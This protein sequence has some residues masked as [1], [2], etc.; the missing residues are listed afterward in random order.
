MRGC[1]EVSF[2]VDFKKDSHSSPFHH[3]VVISYCK[4]WQRMKI[5][6]GEI[7]F[8]S[9]SIHFYLILVSFVV[10]E[11][12]LNDWMRKNEGTILNQGKT[13]ISKISFIPRS[14]CHS[15]WI[16]LVDIIIP[17][18][19]SSFDHSSLIQFSGQLKNH[20]SWRIDFVSLWKRLN[21]C[22]LL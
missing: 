8:N 22:C 4:E 21:G 3:S 14:F 10:Y 13:L 19:W 11:W 20:P 1:P 5:T 16:S 12:C 17:L 7:S 9:H 18:I 15:I 2:F 6:N